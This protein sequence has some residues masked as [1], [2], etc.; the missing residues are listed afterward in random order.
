MN[1]VIYSPLGRNMILK[2]LTGK[3]EKVAEIGVLR[4]AYAAHLAKI[5]TLKELHLVDPWMK[6]SKQEY[7]DHTSKTQADWD[8]TYQFVKRKFEKDKRVVIH[9]QT[10]EAAMP[11]FPDNYF[12]LIYIDANHSYKHVLFDIG[13]AMQKVRPGGYVSG[14]D[15]S[16]E[17]VQK[18]IAAHYD[19]T[20]T[21]TTEKKNSVGHHTIDASWFFRLP[22]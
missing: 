3:I 18:A 9:R 11:A 8:K 4:G 12:D 5:P 10:S 2:T 22:G 13:V 17:R 21:L 19:G 1:K 6:F 20:I 7:S 15:F 14:H 16:L